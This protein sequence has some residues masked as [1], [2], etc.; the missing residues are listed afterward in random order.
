MVRRDNERE[1][2]RRSKRRSKRRRRRRRTYKKREQV[3]G[4]VRRDK[5]HAQA[6]LLAEGSNHS[7]VQ[8]S[9]ATM[10]ERPAQ[11]RPIARSPLTGRSL[12]VSVTS[13]R[14]L[15]AGE[16]QSPGPVAPACAVRPRA[17]DG[18]SAAPHVRR[19]EADDLRAPPGA[20]GRR[21]CSQ[22]RLSA[23]P[24]NRARR[25]WRRQMRRGGRAGE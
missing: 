25:R 4:G 24:T 19:L 3:D 8:I 23:V 10:R 15:G 16:D 20:H 13:W 14:A 2:E 18:G 6:P 17:N 1:R 12:R 21:R 22:H 9:Q 7:I 5:A 11:P